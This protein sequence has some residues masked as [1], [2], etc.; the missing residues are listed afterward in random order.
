M[1]LRKAD[2]TQSLIDKYVN[3]RI[4]LD[5]RHMTDAIIITKDQYV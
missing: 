1:V 5:V 2:I 3:A 4:W